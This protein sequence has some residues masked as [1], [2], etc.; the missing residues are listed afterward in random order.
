MS[1][2]SNEEV[3]RITED[4]L[5]PAQDPPRALAEKII[6]RIGDEHIEVERKTVVTWRDILQADAD[7]MVDYREP[8]SKSVG[9]EFRSGVLINL[10]HDIAI[11]R[12]EGKK[13]DREIYR[14]LA[15]RY[16]PD[17]YPD[18]SE[19]VKALATEYFQALVALRQ[20]GELQVDQSPNR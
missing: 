13:T 3:I 6:I 12:I 2:Q 19:E 15:E 17:L 20:N 5:S 4:D 14:V 10:R 11:L 1:E 18:A 9:T 7:S 8:V 16:H